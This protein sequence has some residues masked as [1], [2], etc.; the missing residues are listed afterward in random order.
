MVYVFPPPPASGSNAKTSF[1]S[2]IIHSMQWKRLK[3]LMH[4]MEWKRLR[5]LCVVG[6][7]AVLTQQRG[8]GLV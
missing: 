5:A 2:R 4:S 3:V 8:T 1:P 6:G 7:E